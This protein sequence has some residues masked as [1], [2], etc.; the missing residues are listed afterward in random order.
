MNLS[1]LTGFLRPLQRPA[2]RQAQVDGETRALA[3]Y[4]SPLCGYCLRVRRAIWRLGL[5]IELRRTDTNPRWGHE[6]RLQGG[7]RQ[8]PCLRISHP[9]RTEWLY[10]SDEIIRYLSLRFAS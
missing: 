9:D 4:H 2:A 3:L 5:R 6:L 8:V 7:K 1:W 10:E